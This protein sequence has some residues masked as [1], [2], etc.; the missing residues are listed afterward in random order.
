MLESTFVVPILL[1]VFDDLGGFPIPSDGIGRIRSGS[2]E[3][4]GVPTDRL[5]DDGIGDLIGFLD[6][7]G[8]DRPEILLNVPG[9]PARRIPKLC[10]DS[11]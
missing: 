2:D 7:K 1:G 5:V 8:S 6:G 4:M 11:Y 10:H 3:D 9:A